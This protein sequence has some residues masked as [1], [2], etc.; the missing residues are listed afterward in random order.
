MVDPLVYGNG[1]RLS[2]ENTALVLDSASDLPRA[3]ERHRNWRAVPI[4][5]TFGTETLRD[6]ID[7]A[8][9]EVYRRL[10]AGADPP[11]TAAPSPADFAA[12][13]ADLA[14]FEH[15]I[16]LTVSAK[17]SATFDSARIAA[18]DSGHGRVTCID[19]GSVSGGVVLLAD[20]IQRRLERGTTAEELSALVERY[21]H[22]A[23]YLY[24][25]ETLEYLARGGRIGRASALAGG[26]LN[27]RP[28]IE[29]R[30]GENV[31]FRR[32]RGRA[33]SVAVLEQALVEATDDVPDLHVGVVHADADEAAA[34]LEARVRVLRPRAGVDLV[35]E[36][37]A[38]LAA[39]VGPGALG[40]Y[41]FCDRS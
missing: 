14:A 16:A 15:V 11:H 40:V 37:G 8:P 41:W 33:R 18:R 31:P 22:E 6:S 17:L 26:L 24:T 5:V 27:T 32:V 13:Y 35:T 19:S 21:R 10:R 2:S 1:M 25:L 12:A 39:H 30:D 28:V 29:V 23:R 3:A 9:A 34:A 20:A 4:Y 7:I 38:A 36:F